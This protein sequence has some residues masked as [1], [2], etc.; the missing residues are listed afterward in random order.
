MITIEHKE[1]EFLP[2]CFLAMNLVK[3]G[4][5]VY[6]GSSEA[7]HEIAKNIQ[8]SIFFHKSTHPKSPYYRS[9]GHKFVLMDEEGGVTT[10]FSTVEQFCKWR[11]ETI[12][13]ERQDL[14]FL[15]G[16]RWS[17]AVLAMPNLAG[18]KVHVTGWP[19]VDLWRSEFAI[20]HDTDVQR[21]LD[22]HGTFYLFPTSFGAGHS[23]SFSEV[24]NSSPDEMFKRIQQHKFDGFQD[25][26]A[27]LKS[28]VHI[29]P[30]GEKIVIRPHPS[31]KMSEWKTTLKGLPN[32]DVIREGDISP[33][34]LAAKS[35]LQFGS[36]T[37]TQAALNGKVNVQYKVRQELG[38][39]DSPSF[40]LSV[41]SHSPEEAYRLLSE[42]PQNTSEIVQRAT[43]VLENEMDFDYGQLAVA[44]IS[45]ILEEE[46]LP[47]VPSVR[48]SIMARLKIG[49]YYYGSALRFLMQRMGLSRSRGK[50]V[51]ENIK[52]GISAREVSK[53]IGSL[54]AV[55]GWSRVTLC[56]DI[57]RN[58]VCISPR[59]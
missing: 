53:V 33:W 49:G 26:V 3:R 17:D 41:N 46:A 42:I 13:D 5:R 4:F 54:E 45:C 40:E 16:K 34:I 9:L 29:L 22:K 52:G 20:V 37:V 8:P 31:E 18:V 58:V 57:A 48:V 32:I 44:K 30:D 35:I 25:Y 10:P 56:K 43:R 24:I 50:T 12:S 39:T 19:R 11:Y 28:L 15:P 23:S 55:E 7:I 59:T 14:I 27:L 2:K 36:T 51:F 21:I 38:V 47:P 1:R 6:I